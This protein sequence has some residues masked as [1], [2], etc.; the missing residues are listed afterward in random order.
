M[1]ASALPPAGSGAAASPARVTRSSGRLS[2]STEGSE[3]SPGRRDQRP[4]NSPL[5]PHPGPG[6]GAKG[7]RPHLV[8]HNP[9]MDDD[10]VVGPGTH[11][12]IASAPPPA[13]GHAHPHA[14]AHGAHGNPGAEPAGAAGRVSPVRTS[15][16]EEAYVG[17]EEEEEEYD[18][19]DGDFEEFD[20]C[21]SPTP[22]S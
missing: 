5:R 21:V 17:E 3:S 9:H 15:A 19:E 7:G 2:L 13:H 6:A 1:S 12:L 22:W 20:P 4:L 16:E 8:A 14:H 10:A 18:D 11:S